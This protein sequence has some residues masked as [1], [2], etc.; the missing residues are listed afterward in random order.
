MDALRRPV[1][2]DMIWLALVTLALC[3]PFLGKAYHMDDTLVVW[4]AQRITEHPADFYGFEV[5]WFGFYAPMVQVYLNPPGA[6]YYSALFGALL[7]WSEPVMHAGMALIAVTL[8]L[9]VYRL[10][11]RMKGDPLPAAVLALVSPGILVSMGTLMTDLPMT[12]LW[13]WATV[14]WLHGLDAQRPT[15]NAV[16]GL[17]IGLAALTKYFAI[18]LA[19]LLLVYTLLSG[20]RRWARAAWLALPV[21]LLGLL[22]LYTHRRYGMSQFLETSGVLK[23]FHEQYALDPWR[24]MLTGLAFLG[25]GGAPAL[26]IAPWLWRR[27][28]RVALCAGAA[29]MAA[30]TVVL[31]RSGWE[32]GLPQVSYSWWFWL[33][34]GLWILAGLHILALAFSEVW[35]RRDREA[36]LLGLW[37]VGTLLFGIFVYHFVNIRVIL[38]ALPAVALLCARRVRMRSGFGA[39]AP[40]RA[41]WLGLAAGLALS[42]CVAYSDLKLANSARTAA[43]R[44]APEKRQGRTWFSGHWG[45]Q[46]YMEARGAKPIDVRHPDIRKGDTLV[47]P[48]NASNRIRIGGRGAYI[49][50]SFEVPVCSWL[51]T[52]RAECGAGFYSDLW[53]PLPFVFG[54]APPEQYEVNGL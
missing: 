7:G 23:A 29:G 19:P 21:V 24:K 6:A 50:E 44:I 28:G 51:T 46:Y 41:V 43:E 35:D 13:V 27:A 33:Q 12:A 37:L 1:R 17:L 54:P 47:T 48:M 52:M 25:A 30:V 22:D 2:R 3:G 53:G 10:A 5:N 34:Y 31:A 26:F 4:T 45:F 14:L 15:A 38:P 42:V 18:S 36:A 9:G 11:R 32:A 16:S 40:P 39:P 8:V 20:R 49:D